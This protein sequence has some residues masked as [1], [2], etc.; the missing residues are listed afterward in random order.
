MFD[1]LDIIDPRPFF[2]AGFAAKAIKQWPSREGGGF[3]FRLYDGRKPVALVRNDGNGG[4]TDYDWV[5]L[6][7][8]GAVDIPTGESEVQTAAIRRAAAFSTAAKAKLEGLVALLPRV[9]D[10][11]VTVGWIGDVLLRHALL[12]RDCHRRT[13]F[14]R[15]DDT[16]VTYATVNK[17]YSP[18]VQRWIDAKHPGSLVYNV[19]VNEAIE[20]PAWKG[21]QETEDATTDGVIIFDLDALIARVVEV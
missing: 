17:A 5:G 12:L 19:W 6:R 13:C 7:W 20:V 16:D 3:Q 2:A 9:D 10:L 1:M 15:P 21:T 11:K 14:R 8:D 4:P 18:E